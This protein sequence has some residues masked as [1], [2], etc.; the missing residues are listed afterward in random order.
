VLLIRRAGRG[1]TRFARELT[2]Q[3]RLNGAQ[4][5]WGECYAE[6][7]SPYTPMAQVIRSSQDVQGFEH[8]E[9]SA[10]PLSPIS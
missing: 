1:K 4:V 6:G 10:N 8:L 3:A 9:V 2:A 7:S 5:L